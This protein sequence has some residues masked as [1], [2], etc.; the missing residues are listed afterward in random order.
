M[1]ATKGLALG[2]GS[3]SGHGACPAPIWPGADW[4]P[5]TYNKE[6]GIMCLDE[7]MSQEWHWEPKAH[8]VDATAGTHLQQCPG[9]RLCSRLHTEEEGRQPGS[10]FYRQTYRKEA[11]F[12]VCPNPV[13]PQSLLA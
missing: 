3:G 6:D 2:G 8:K 13:T 4:I 9:A 7:G 10:T 12:Q 11:A 1:L 5:K